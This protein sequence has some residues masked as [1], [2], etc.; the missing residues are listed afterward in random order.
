MSL[1]H[2]HLAL[3]HVPVVGLFAVLGLFFWALVRRNSEVARAGFAALVLIACV[4]AIVFL[5]GEPAEDAVE[6]LAGVTENSIDQHKELAEAAFGVTIGVG[7]LALLAFVGYLRREIPR[8]AVATGMV[9]TLGV[10]SLMAVTA[11]LGGRI[12]HSEIGPSASAG[13]GIRETDEH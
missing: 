8:W 1:V 5:T 2:W 9:V 6:K 10:S 11:N 4:T 3:T 12:R 13:Q 7:V